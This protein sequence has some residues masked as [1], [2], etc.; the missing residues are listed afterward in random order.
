MRLSVMAGLVPAIHD[1]LGIKK[2]VDGRDKH[3]HD[4]WKLRKSSKTA[5]NQLFALAVLSSAARKPRASLS[6]SSFAQKCMKN[7]RGCSVEHVAVQRRHLDAVLAQR[8]D[9]RVDLIRRQHEVAGDRRLAAAGRLE[10]DAVAT[11]IGPAGVSCM[12]LSLIG[13]RRGTAN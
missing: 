9:H 1:C 8:L 12:P 10:V 6:A 4:D 5:C 11:P 3:G 7:S 2:D 13:S